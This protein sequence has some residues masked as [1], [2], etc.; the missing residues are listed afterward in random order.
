MKYCYVADTIAGTLTYL[1]HVSCC[2]KALEW[3]DG[4]PTDA[5]Y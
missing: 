3:R 1:K 2:Q 4:Q 5:Q